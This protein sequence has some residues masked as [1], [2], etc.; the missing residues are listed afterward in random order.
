MIVV[1]FNLYPLKSVYS[2]ASNWVYIIEQAK[3]SV[4][5][6]LDGV[7]ERTILGS[8]F[9]INPEGFIVTNFHVIEKSQRVFVKIYDEQIHPVEVLHMNADLDIAILYVSLINLPTLRLGNSNNIKD[10]EDIIAIGAPMGLDYSVTSGI[11]GN[12]S[13]IINEKSYIQ[14]SVPIFPGNSGGPLINDNG[15]VIGVNTFMLEDTQGIGFAIPINEVIKYINEQ[16]IVVELS[17]GS[18]MSAIPP[19][20]FFEHAVAEDSFILWPYLTVLAGIIFLLL[21]ILLFLFLKKNKK[22]KEGHEKTELK[23]NQDE[24]NDLDIEL[25]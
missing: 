15:E 2:G 3:P 11:I 21:T 22:K 14:I 17:L 18:E 8:G 24:F 10:G 1:Y 7:D 6:I 20:E 25:K 13:R 12:P 5:V 9:F 16:G 23:N 4:V 19:L